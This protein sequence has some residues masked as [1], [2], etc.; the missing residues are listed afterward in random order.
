MKFHKIFHLHNQINA[1]SQLGNV[2]FL[3]DHP[4]IQPIDVGEEWM[5]SNVS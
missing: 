3:P 4:T 5:D 2:P 1:L